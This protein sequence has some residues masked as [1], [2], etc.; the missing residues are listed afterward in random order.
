MVLSIINKHKGS[1]TAKESIDP[2]EL[3]NIIHDIYYASEKS[4]IFIDNKEFNLNSA[5]SILTNFI[6][7][8]FD[9]KRMQNITMQELKL[10][11]LIICEMEPVNSYH[12]VM[13]SHF[14]IVKDFNRCITKA[15]FEE[16]VNISSKIL[17][18]LGE[19]IY[20]EPKII[21]DILIEAFMNAPGFNGI[22]QD[23]FYNLWLSHQDSKFST[24]ANLF[25]LMI[26]FKKSESVIHQY[27][28][29]GCKRF[30]IIG[31]RYKCQKCKI[32]LCFDCFS[33]GYTSARHSFGHR[34][35]ELSTCEKDRQGLISTMF[36][37]FLSIFRQRSSATINI[38]QELGNTKLIEEEH[39]ELVQVDDDMDVGTFRKR[40]GTIRSEV[41]N[42]SENLLIHQRDLVDKLFSATESLK[43]ESEKF[44]ENL[45]KTANHELQKDLKSHADF[46]NE[47]VE[48]YQKIHEELAGTFNRNQSNNT[49]RPFVS[50]SKSIF[51]PSSTP[52][53]LK[54]KSKTMLSKSSKIIA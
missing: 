42:N 37:K 41:Y 16:F 21:N 33:K 7:N 28:C 25:L 9:P 2:I 50:P 36:D 14:E 45:T 27:D 24:Y 26:R 19:P 8:I 48:V 32:S 43:V 13:D 18:Y 6:W 15:R 47:Q 54:E 22:S 5:I 10:T 3:T 34:F 40:R 39:I 44:N 4:G 12:S 17:S 51:L 29:T 11:M 46:L 20:F 53:M 52:Y 31:L 30:P 35:F 49:I 23:V 38:E 1:K